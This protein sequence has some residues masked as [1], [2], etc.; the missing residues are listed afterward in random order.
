M[1]GGIGA[2]LEA[3][4]KELLDLGLRNP[5]LNHRSRTRQVRVVD[6]KAAE[7]YRLLVGERQALA[8]EPLPD[9]VADRAEEEAAPDTEPDWS[10]LLA[11]PDEDPATGGVAARHRDDRLQ[12]SM[13]SSRLQARLLGSFRQ[14]R[15]DGLLVSHE[16]CPALVWATTKSRVAGLLWK[17]RLVTP[18]Q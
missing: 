1:N 14:Q 13:I 7:V 4:R 15:P 16:H 5:L 2:R 9:E 8:F 11:Q 17:S 18:K 10:D 6:E 3:A 12:N